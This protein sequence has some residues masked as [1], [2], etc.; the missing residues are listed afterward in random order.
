MLQKE[1]ADYLKS[2][3]FDPKHSAAYSGPEKMYRIVKKEEKYKIGRHLIAQWLQNQ[4]E[5][6]LQ[7]A[8]RRK[9]KRRR[10]VVSGT[11]SQWDIDLANVENIGKYNDSFTYL[12]FVIDVFFF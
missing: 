4:D 3:H 8:V 10:V 12:L 7:R 5:Y 1:N 6:S 2:I 9:F 11:D